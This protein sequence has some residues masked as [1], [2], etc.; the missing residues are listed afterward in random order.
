ML[1]FMQQPFLKIIKIWYPKYTRTP[2]SFGGV[3]CNF[4]LD[5]PLTIRMATARF[6]GACCLYVSLHVVVR[7]IPEPTVLP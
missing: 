2:A 4:P 5:N 1:K 6:S 7:G 3:C